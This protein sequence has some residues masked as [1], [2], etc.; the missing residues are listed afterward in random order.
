MNR[1]EPFSR[2][3]RR[4]LPSMLERQ[5]TNVPFK[6]DETDISERKTIERAVR[7]LND[8]HPVR[9][10]VWGFSATLPASVRT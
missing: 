7:A 2:D 1:R 5:K 9:P 6:D 4:G 10:H 8:N 3:P